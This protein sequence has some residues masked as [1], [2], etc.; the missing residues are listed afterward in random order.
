[1]EA[2]EQEELAP[3]WSIL[4]HYPGGWYFPTPAFARGRGLH[5]PIIPPS[6]AAGTWLKLLLRTVFL[7]SYLAGFLINFVV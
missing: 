2:A 1:V 4:R 6:W 3:P 5:W 7:D